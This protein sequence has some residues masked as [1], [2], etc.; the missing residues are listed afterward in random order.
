MNRLF[1]CICAVFTLTS[2]LAAAEP[3]E[4][5]HQQIRA[6][7]EELLAIP[8]RAAGLPGGEQAARAI[9]AHLRS[10]GL[11]P[12]IVPHRVAVAAD[13]GSYIEVGDKRIAVVPHRPNKAATAGTG[14]KKLTGEL[15]F[16][17]QGRY[18]DLNGRV[19]EGAIV[20]LDPDSKDAW[21][22]A[23]A[24]GAAAVVFRGTKD[25]DSDQ[26]VLQ[27]VNASLEFP[28]FVAELD[29]ALDREQVSITS[30]VAWQLSD[31]YSVVALLRGSERL[32]ESVILA[33]GYESPSFM[34]PISQGATRAW[35]AALLLELTRQMAAAPPERD[36]LVVFHGVRGEFMRGLRSIV[37]ALVFERQ[38]NHTYPIGSQLSTLQR[39]A[40]LRCWEA[41]RAQSALS[42]L[43]ADATL[44]EL[45]DTLAKTPLGE[46]PMALKDADIELGPAHAKSAVKLAKLLLLQQSAERADELQIPLEAKRLLTAPG[47]P[48]GLTDERITQLR[49]EIAEDLKPYQLYRTVQ[50]KLEFDTS[51]TVEENAVIPELVAKALVNLE[52]HLDVIERERRDLDALVSLRRLECGSPIHL[53]GLDLSDGNEKFS[54]VT[55][56]PLVSWANDI[57]WLNNLLSKQISRDSD[58]RV[59]EGL[60]FDIQAHELQSDSLSYFP[61]F[62][63]HEAGIAGRWLNGATLAT[64]ND[65]RIK[66]GSPADS[67]AAFRA[68][69]FLTQCRSMSRFLRAYIDY[70]D[71]G[72]RKAMGLKVANAS[73][74]LSVQ[75]RSVGG[76]SISRQFAYPLAVVRWGKP[77]QFPVFS[78][79]VAAREV[80]L[81]DSLGTIFLP[82]LPSRHPYLEQIRVETYGVDASGRIEFAQSENLDLDTKTADLTTQRPM[83][84]KATGSR[85]F[86]LLDPRLM[87]NLDTVS[88]L[89]ATREAPPQF[90]HVELDT[91]VGV[92]AIFSEPERALRITATQGKIGNRLV[93][94]GKTTGAVGPDDEHTRNSPWLRLYAVLLALA[95]AVLSVSVW[96]WLVNRR[97]KSSTGAAMACAL[98]AV[99]GIVASAWPLYRERASPAPAPIEHVNREEI[100]I[101]PGRLARL[102]PLDVAKDLISLNEARLNKLRANGINSDS[103]VRLHSRAQRELKTAEEA[104]ARR[105]YARAVG[106]AHGAWAYAGRVYP[107]VLGTANDVV[108]GLVV[109]LLFAI[110]FALIA[111]RLFIAGS[112]VVKK[113]AGFAGFFVI[114][115]L[116]FYF[117]H[118][119]FAIAAT[120][121]F[122]F[123][124]FIIL[125]TSCWV[126]ALIINRFEGEMDLLR[127]SN[128]GVHKAD[129]S[130]LGTLFATMALGIS[131]MRRRPIRTF[132]TGITVVLMTFILLTFASFNPAIGS[133]RIPLESSSP[134]DGIL[135]RQ[136]GWKGLSEDSLERVQNTW[137]IDLA[138]SAVR[139]LAPR[140]DL[141]KFPVEGPKGTSFISGIA[142][143][144]PGDPSHIEDA[145]CRGEV[146]AAT[147]RGFGGDKD[148]LFL[149]PAIIKRAGLVPGTMAK[150]RGERVRIGTIDLSI[151]ASRP[152]LGGES[153]LPLTPDAIDVNRQKELD[154]AETAAAEGSPQVESTSF[155]HLGAGSVGIMHESRVNTVG[156][157]LRAISLTPKVSSS[158]NN[159][160]LDLEEIADDIAQQTALTL[161]VGAH[162][163]SYLM[164]GVNSLSVAGLGSVLIPLILGGLIIFSTMLNSVA[165]RG[166]EI[167]I[168][169]SL[170]L[171]PI[172]VAALFLVE[173]SIYAVLGGLCGY[174]LAQLMV[175]GLG[176]AA[177]FG[178]GVQPDLNYSSFTAVTTILLV[179]ATVLLSSLYPALVASRAANPG[180]SDFRVPKPQGDE[181][182]LDFPFTVAARD[183]RGLLAYLANYFSAHTEAS[184]ACFTAADPV[185]QAEPERKLYTVS[186]K[187]WLAPFD[188]GI[189]QQLTVHAKPTDVKA[190]Y[191]VQLHLVLLS[192][193]RSTWRRAN[194]TFLKVLRQQFLV[195]RTLSPRT[196]DHYRSL[197]GDEDARERLLAASAE[198]SL[199]KKPDTA[200]FAKGPA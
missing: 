95:V 93:L 81:G 175:S 115:F 41:R 98:I 167:F 89:G 22:H 66:V 69:S 62:Y 121:M 88:P 168:Y 190:I 195:W 39:N 74:E 25:M 109:M 132:L 53:I 161:R 59:I 162:G 19:I 166:K 43:S 68:E 47:N 8:A 154:R 1:T 200:L 137:G 61:D 149:P 113:I 104:F 31:A 6:Y 91:D 124:A 64:T 116:F 135:I 171:A 170:G 52:R 181:L 79:E 141:P 58:G 142:G 55:V 46:T 106:S 86:D 187:V 77:T 10:F 85:L 128:M 196:M 48:R 191:A 164:T 4:A 125:I 18:E 134:Y 83:V 5:D 179:M 33:A 57:E 3:K 75:V 136:N 87:V 63:Q 169:A 148:W 35:N 145:L 143:F 76:K 120:P 72:S 163:E 24:L 131:N 156:G 60:A 185:L 17:G 151:M 193:Q 21:M 133:K 42:Q 126:I 186:A 27:G 78:G 84:F 16:A 45:I 174:I 160:R 15:I 176:L 100:G 12:I 188:L 20:V 7:A 129:V 152:Y 49:D 103:L 56:G 144:S 158:A 90:C 70:P 102:T 44:A 36:T 13:K 105:D 197:G 182:N 65:R 123:L 173:A 94:L 54:S 157:Y 26:L 138:V 199:P 194:I 118:P 51:F 97:A 184:T 147:P 34:S 82:F 155:T 11:E 150:F 108:Y 178:W 9:A 159:N 114:I 30:T 38:V 192:G 110:P 80:Y 101:A 139:W 180:T 119:A 32:D 111:E 107:Q 96:R 130:R 29:P 50:Q 198:A 153:I 183:I 172:H 71:L 99:A 165:E 122:I 112:T 92:A 14:G 23:A 2:T 127:M 73:P 146:N 140:N 177:D 67:A 117:F 40:T 28:R 189:S 37:S